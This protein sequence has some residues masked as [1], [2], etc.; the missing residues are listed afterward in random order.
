M[1]TDNV[2]DEE[3][4]FVI[5]VADPLE[6]TAFDR[7]TPNV[8]RVLGQREGMDLLA[9]PVERMQ[10]GVLLSGSLSESLEFAKRFGVNHI[11]IAAPVIYSE[12]I[13]VEID[14]LLMTSTVGGSVVIFESTR[15]AP[16]QRAE[17]VKLGS[18]SIE[19]DDMHFVWN[20]PPSQVDGGTMFSVNDN[21]LIRMTDCSVT[22]ENL[23]SLD[24]VYAFDIETQPNPVEW[25]G[26]PESFGDREALPLVAIELNNVIVRGQMTMIHMDY[27]TEL[28]LHWDNGLLAITERMLDTGGSRVRPPVTAPPMLLSLTRLTAHAPLG[29]LR[30]RLGAAE[31]PMEIDRESRSSV[32]IVDAGIPHVDIV[33]INSRESN[34]PIIKF[35]G[36]ANAYDVRS[37]NAGSNSIDH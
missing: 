20:V 6:T 9:D 10:D 18:N 14:G 19:F 4:P 17:M 21:R 31:Y 5:D 32:F 23:L 1:E 7:I 24:A 26:Q 25:E 12:P 11:E 30:M 16:L 2:A 3:S 33:G 35:R 27:A 28:Q 34:Q 15:I 8:I 13:K 22:I 36:E 29:L 37:R